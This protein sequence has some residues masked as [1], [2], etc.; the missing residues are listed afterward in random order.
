[1]GVDEEKLE[2]FL[3][4]MEIG[5]EGVE[6]VGAPYI[7]RA[8]VN[9]VIDL[10]DVDDSL[11]LTRGDLTAD[12]K[13][14]LSGE[15]SDDVYRV[16]LVEVSVDGGMTWEAAVGTDRWSYRFVPEEGW[17][18]ELLF[19]AKNDRGV[20]CDPCDFGGPWVVT[21]RDVDAEEIAKEIVEKFVLCFETMD[22]SCLE[23]LVSDDYDGVFHNVHSKDDLIEGVEEGPF[24]S[25]FVDVDYQIRQINE[26]ADMI[27]CSL[28]WAFTASYDYG[29]RIEESNIT[30]WLSKADDYRMI[31]NEGN[32]IA[33]DEPGELKLMNFINGLF[34][35]GC[36]RWVKILL[37]APNIP[38]SVN[39][40]SV[41]VDTTC[42][43][44]MV[45]LS[46]TYYE[47]ETGKDDGFGGE[48]AMQGLLTCITPS[49]TG[50]TFYAYETASKELVVTF[51]DY[52]YDFY[53]TITLP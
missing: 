27:I 32:I 14:L 13:V 2:Q 25:N 40:V 24:S 53:E 41:E 12:G 35:A 10:E 21:Y 28:N 39:T 42:G 50:A 11:Y 19:R 48:V 47:A 22:S 36:D 37:V 7:D 5:G 30:V 1:M 4:E 18:Y 52:G 3:E 9:T 38:D 45:T 43:G 6:E 29:D 33:S 26:T 23:E 17:E 20:Y 15:A 31:H 16:S 46:R 51:Q 8:Y 44:G 49:C 34:V